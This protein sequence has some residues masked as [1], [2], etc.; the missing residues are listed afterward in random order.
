MLG[1][2]GNNRYGEPLLPN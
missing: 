2:S 1:G